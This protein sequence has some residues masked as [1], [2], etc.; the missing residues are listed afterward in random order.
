MKDKGLRTFCRLYIDGFLASLPMSQSISRSFSQSSNQLT[1]QSGI[2]QNLVQVTLRFILPA[3]LFVS[4]LASC[5]GSGAK[6]ERIAPTEKFLQNIGFNLHN[7]KSTD[8]TTKSKKDS[9]TNAILSEENLANDTIIFAVG[10]QQFADAFLNYAIELQNM[11]YNRLTDSCGA[12]AILFGYTAAKNEIAA[13]LSACDSAAAL[14]YR[15]FLYATVQ[16][17]EKVLY[18]TH[19]PYIDEELYIPFAKHVTVSNFYPDES[20]LVYSNQLKLMSKNRI[21]TKANDITFH[22]DLEQTD[23]SYIS[24]HN[25]VPHAK[26]PNTYVLLYLYDP[27]CTS[28]NKSTIKLLNNKTIE[29]LLN[30]ERL[31]IL[32]IRDNYKNKIHS[33]Q[34]PPA[35]DSLSKY[36]AVQR[37][38]HKEKDDGYFRNWGY[39]YDS[40][41]MLF[42]SIS[43]Y[44]I[45]AVP[46]FYLLT[47][48]EKLVL[49]K[50]APVERVLS[51]LEHIE[52]TK[53]EN[54][55]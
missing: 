33:E 54:H 50:D 51:Y 5:T 8:G 40:D 17:A 7:L 20:K 22:T 39:F 31:I 49:I 1:N 14:G 43:E 45:R 55:K 30:E 37:E 28:C 41:D 24:L 2:L 21:G 29:N 42:Y 26:S 44:V 48:K 27:Y 46:S 4:V 34:I 35:Q 38:L 13:L 16:C 3:L 36:I 18:N 6:Q 25:V 32:S 19:S 52:V 12:K 53:E 10:Q 11:I 47:G 9:A 15:R 23:S